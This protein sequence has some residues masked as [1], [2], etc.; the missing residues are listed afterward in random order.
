LPAGFGQSF[1]RGWIRREEAVVALLD[2]TGLSS[3]TEIKSRIEGYPMQQPVVRV[4]I[5]RC[6][7][8]KFAEFQQMMIEAD[9]VLRP[10]IEA[11]P[12]LINF[13]AGA[14][15]ATSSLTNVSLWKTLDNAKQLDTFQPMLDLGKAFAQKGATFERPV[16]NYLTLWQLGGSASQ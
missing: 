8:E 11:M 15:Q 5:F 14:D 10:G 1:P 4:S 9:S 6:V 3:S 7:P 13:Y 2:G 16:M 12:G